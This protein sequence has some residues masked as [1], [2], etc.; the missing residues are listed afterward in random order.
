LS[1]AAGK[2]E[3]W[4]RQGWPW[5]LLL[6]PAS[7]VIASFVTLYIAINNE[8]SLV[9]DDYYKEGLAINRDLARDEF[10]R[11]HGISGVLRFDSETLA[12]EVRLDSALAPPPG[13][14]L[15]ILHPTDKARD[16]VIRMYHLAGNVFGG[17][18]S[19]SLDGRY[20]L[21][22]EPVADDRTA[23]RVRGTLVTGHLGVSTARLDAD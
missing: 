10:A 13:L 19:D 20:Y 16:Q 14:R 8:D 11:R 3:P 12:I 9:K 2:P 15:E 7:V 17:K 18:A 21:L 22:L 6:L 23:W 4:Y 5:F 1:T